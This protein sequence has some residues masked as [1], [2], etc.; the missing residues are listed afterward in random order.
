MATR[1]I[2]VSWQKA[3]R[4]SLLGTRKPGAPAYLYHGTADTIVPIA[5]G[6]ML[7]HDWCA[8]G[9]SVQYVALPGLE[10]ISGFIAGAPAGVQWLADRLAGKQAVAGCHEVS[11]P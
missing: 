8:Q 5:Q 1:V 6:D 7:Y 11:L 3:Y 2:N 4:A 10:H 9:A